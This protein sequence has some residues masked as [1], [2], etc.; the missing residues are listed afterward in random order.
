MA[1]GFP[2][3]R[4]LSYPTRTNKWIQASLKLLAT[5]LCSLSHPIQPLTSDL[6]EDA[7]NRQGGQLIC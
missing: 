3:D 4:N 7:E 6:D 5:K 1:V 2:D